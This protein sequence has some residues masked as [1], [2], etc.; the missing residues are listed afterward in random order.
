MLLIFTAVSVYTYLGSHGFF[1]VE[2]NFSFTLYSLS[3]ML[4]LVLLLSSLV[5]FHFSANCSHFRKWNFAVYLLV[6]FHGDSLL[7][8]YDAM[9]SCLITKGMGIRSYITSMAALCVLFVVLL[10]IPAAKLLMELILS[11]S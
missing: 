8:I 2:Y 1:V 4:L 7:I 3:H 10:N 9:A 5:K 6:T 11:L